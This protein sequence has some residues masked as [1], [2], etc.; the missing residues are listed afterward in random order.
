MI[1]KIS[2]EAAGEISMAPV[3][4][5]EMALKE[6]VGVILSVSGKDA[7]RIGDLLQRGSVVQ[8]ASRFRWQPVT[9]EQLQLRSMLAEF[10]DSEPSRPLNWERCRHARLC[11]H[12]AAVE[13]PRELVSGKRFLR[14]SSF[15]D[16]LMSI[17]RE[18]KPEYVEY[19]YREN[20]DVY[21]VALNADARQQ[22]VEA[23]KL[24]KY[25]GMGQQ[26]AQR[27]FK[28]LELVVGR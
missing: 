17:A 3:V 19:S 28:T 10:P 8:G 22:I 27:E 18:G 5:Q 21:R 9:V 24:L 16:A 15:W 23:S 25:S 2:S 14:R 26:I 4:A 20:G 12:R 11:G 13:L 1:V 6:L 7:Q